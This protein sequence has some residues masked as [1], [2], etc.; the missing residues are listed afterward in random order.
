MEDSWFKRLLNR[1]QNQSTA[2]LV[3]WGIALTSLL[4]FVINLLSSSSFGADADGWLER[5]LADFSTDLAGAGIAFLF[6][7]YFLDRREKQRAASQ[8][9]SIVAQQAEETHP[10]SLTYYIEAEE[11]PAPA[12][13]AVNEELEEAVENFGEAL[14][15]LIEAIKA[16]ETPEARQIH[17]DRV[18][19]RGGFVHSTLIGI[20][21][22]R[23]DLCDTNLS[24]AQL[25]KANLREANMQG[26]NLRG[27]NLKETQLIE[28]NLR[29][30]DLT[31]ANLEH[32]FLSGAILD[33]AKLV[34]AKI[35]TS[36]WGAS[37]VNADLH[38]A[39]LSGAELFKANL[40]GA[41]LLGANF[42]DA[43]FSTDTILPN[44]SHWDVK[45]NIARF[46]DPRHPQFWRS[47]DSHSPAAAKESRVRVEDLPN[48][49]VASSQ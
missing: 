16:S 32:T 34:R 27:A 22:Q 17:L 11:V 4:S 6:V 37:L 43:K 13:E 31:E 3:I 19:D 35:E 21:L 33:G 18:R 15:E 2:A 28:A 7:K 48:A 29:G 8:E 20:N 42:R 49:G 5:W 24:H 25:V 46:T 45:T 14:E 1:L 47:D 26:V 23:A 10:R 36:L 40:T 41:N 38:D 30:A 9:T 12:A 44:G 39:N